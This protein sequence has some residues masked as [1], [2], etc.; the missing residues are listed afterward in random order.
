[1]PEHNLPTES[2]C[3]I[4]GA[5]H[6]AAQLAPSLRQEGWQGR[7]IIVG[8]ESYLPYHRPPLAKTFMSGEKQADQLLIR[9]QALYDKN[10]IEFK[11]NCRIDHIDR[12]Q[13]TITSST[14]EV[15]AY[16]K[17][18]LCTGS[19]VRRV[20]LPGIDLKGIHYLRD[21]ND[22]DLT[23]QNRATSINF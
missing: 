18:A 3:I 6:A 5:S 2:T 15:M 12:Q 4:I 14:G 16:D 10:N 22:I 7:I 1:M 8:D 23:F 19:R 21:I 9:N 11:L 20:D 17:L 13:K